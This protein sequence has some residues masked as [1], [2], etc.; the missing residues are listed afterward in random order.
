MGWLTAQ[1]PLPLLFTMW[2]LQAQPSR[3]ADAAAEVVQ[4]EQAD[5]P[6]KAAIARSQPD[7]DVVVLPFGDRADGR[8]GQ[9][10]QAQWSTEPQ[11]TADEHILVVQ[12]GAQARV[13][14]ERYRHELVQVLAGHDVEARV[15]VQLVQGVGDADR[16]RRNGR[17]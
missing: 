8:V 4:V 5:G 7:V 9:R 6:G 17:V 12:A 1:P 14:P 16:A 15:P 10:D 13:Q 2:N 3:V 11:F